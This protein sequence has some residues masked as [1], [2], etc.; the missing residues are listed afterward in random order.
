MLTFKNFILLMFIIGIIIITK[1][2]TKRTYECPKKE[3]EYRYMPK[4]MDMD[5]IDSNNIDKIFKSMFQGSEPW[6]SSY[7]ADSNK[8]RKLINEKIGTL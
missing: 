3:I 2:V 5:I 8:F 1:E 4:T 7:R 6:I